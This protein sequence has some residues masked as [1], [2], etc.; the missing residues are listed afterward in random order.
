MRRAALLLVL[1]TR[2]GSTPAS[3]AE[4]IAWDE[5]EKH[6]GEAATVEGQVVG[7]HCSPLSCLLA[8]E[9]SFNRFTA[10]IQAASFEKLPPDRVEREFT[11]QRVRVSGTIKTIDGKPEI[12][13]SDPA[14][15]TIL[16]DE[17][18]PR[19]QAERAARAQD[20]TVERLDDMISRME[21][22]TERLA[23]IQERLEAILA[24]LTAREAAPPAPVPAPGPAPRA[25]FETLRS[26]KIGMT[27]AEV[28]RLA[29]PP[30]QVERAGNGW[31]TWY[32][33][34]GRSVT[35]DGRG[36]ARSMVGFAAP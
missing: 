16:R 20:A 3:A 31:M 9:P 32:Y 6:V 23:A 34:Y 29:G 5:A 10:V 11:G 4:P 30:E 26:I 1:T 22:V 25:G 7:V 8:F 36:R 15:L 19:A 28:E 21:E 35:F 2:L 27:P 13:V 12:V 18:D 14:A 17:P 24:A 33:A